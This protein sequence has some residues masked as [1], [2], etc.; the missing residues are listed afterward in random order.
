MT[1]KNLFCDCVEILTTIHLIFWPASE[2]C[3]YNTSRQCCS[4]YGPEASSCEHRNEHLHSI[5]D[6]KLTKGLTA[7][8]NGLCSTELLS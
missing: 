1:G 4:G 3:I 2:I 8:L 7:S 6:W 5:K